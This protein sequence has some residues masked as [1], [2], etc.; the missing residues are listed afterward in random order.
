MDFKIR[1]RAFKMGDEVFINKLR[2]M[3]KERIRLE[4]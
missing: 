2:K 4:E 1:F 3:K